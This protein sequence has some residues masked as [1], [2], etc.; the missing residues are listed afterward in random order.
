MS[1]VHSQATQ[2]TTP[3]KRKPGEANFDPITP[4]GKKARKDTAVKF[5][6]EPI[7]TPTPGVTSLPLATCVNK[8]NIFLGEQEPSTWAAGKPEK[9][10]NLVFDLWLSGQDPIMTQA[11]IFNE[12]DFPK[13]QNRV[14]K[15]LWIVTHEVEDRLFQKYVVP[16]AKLPGGD[17]LIVARTRL[18]NKIMA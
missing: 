3:S 18:D 6:L 4:G 13:F 17:S 8:P 7:I 16:A 9:P 15:L 11:S 14:A 5:I 12:L 1:N 10:A 2:P